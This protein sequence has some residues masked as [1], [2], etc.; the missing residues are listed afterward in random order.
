M[1]TEIFQ[2]EVGRRL[3]TL[4]Q[5]REKSDY[6]DFYIASKEKAT[7]QFETARLILEEVEKY[8]KEKIAE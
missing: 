8:L 6:D 5:L 2:R 4:K 1:A 3:A 7:E